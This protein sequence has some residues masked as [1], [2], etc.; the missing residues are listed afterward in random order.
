MDAGRRQSLELGKHAGK[1]Q[2]IVSRC[3]DPDTRILE[4]WRWK[5]CLESRRRLMFD[6]PLWVDI[7]EWEEWFERIRE[8]P[9]STTRRCGFDLAKLVGK[10]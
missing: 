4:R 6:L 5:G 10:A 7:V 8:V 3:E 2:E 1:H 9:N